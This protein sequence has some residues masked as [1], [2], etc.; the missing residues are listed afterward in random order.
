ML[1][2]LCL[3]LSNTAQAVPLQITQQGRVLDSTGVTIMGTHDVTFRLYENETTNSP[4]WSE[5]LVISFNNGYYAAILGTNESGNPLGSEVLSLYPLFLEIQLDSNSPMTPR[6]EITSAPYAQISGV[7]ES[8]DGGKVNASEIQ[9]GS[10]PVIDGSRNWIGEPITVDWSQVQNIPAYVS[11]GDDNTQLSEGEVENYVT[12]NG[13]SLHQDTTLNGEEILT[14]GTDS[15]TLA[16]ISCSDGDVPKWDEVTTQW[17]CGL[18][19]DTLADLNCDDG[20]IA[21]WNA[22]SNQWYCSPDT[23]GALNCNDGEF[24]Q[25]N[26]SQEIWNCIDLQEIFD[27]DG[28]GILSWSDCDDTDPTALSQL[29]DNDCD[30]VITSDDCNDNDASST[31]KSIDGDCDNVLT[32]DDCNDDDATLLEQ[33]NDNDCDGAITS[34][35]CDDS[36]P[37]STIKANDADCDGFESD[38]D[39]DDT[40]FNVNPNGT[41][42]NGDG[43]DNDCDGEIDDVLEYTMDGIFYVSEDTFQGDFNSGGGFCTQL[44]GQTAYIARHGISLSGSYSSGLWQGNGSSAHSSHNCN[45]Y[46]SNSSSHSGYGDQGG[47]NSCS[48]ARHVV[49]TTNTSQCNSDCGEWD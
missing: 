29:N 9:I 1:F 10:I 26:A 36:D 5:T 2:H 6:Q 33:S 43:I 8:V 3:Y 27:V 18:D 22:T 37:A 44:V 39:C 28:D 42:V 30:G 23:M 20:D 45:L 7:A 17:S 35:D 4:V 14:L 38:V 16:D 40:E 13:I 15:D 34:A 31:T 11:D 19:K 47:Y 46:S 24:A 41:E 12:N 21:K 25:Y 49:C 48:Q 32:A